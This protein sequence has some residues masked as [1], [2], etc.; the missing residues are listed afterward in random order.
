[1]KIEEKKLG[2][3]DIGRNVLYV[4][5]HA[6]GDTQHKD[7]EVGI[8]WSWNDRS[9]FVRYMKVIDG[10]PRLCQTSEGTNPEDLRWW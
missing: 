7:C 6:N 1:M 9:I 8:I 2:P 4:P 3:D 10:R 5:T